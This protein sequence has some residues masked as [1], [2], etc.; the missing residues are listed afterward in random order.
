MGQLLAI[1][2]LCATIERR[3]LGMSE[4]I[5]RLTPLRGPHRI[6]MALQEGRV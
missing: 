4:W 1:R 6:R 5:F 2:S 3:T